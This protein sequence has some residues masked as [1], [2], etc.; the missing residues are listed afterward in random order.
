MLKVVVLLP[1]LQKRATIE[2]HLVDESTCF[3]PGNHGRHASYTSTLLVKDR[4]R[5][6]C[7]HMKTANMHLTGEITALV[8]GK[9]ALEGRVHNTEQHEDHADGERGPGSGINLAA[10]PVAGLAVWLR[11]ECRAVSYTHLTLPTILLV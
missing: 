1:A 10:K 3:L 9:V 6:Q 2:T 11:L 7:T 8:Q 5:T 4:Y